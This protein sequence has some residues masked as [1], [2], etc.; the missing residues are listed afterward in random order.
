MKIYDLTHI[1]SKYQKKGIKKSLLSILVNN[2]QHS[3]AENA[4]GTRFINIVEK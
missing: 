2:N 1:I 3:L 4:P